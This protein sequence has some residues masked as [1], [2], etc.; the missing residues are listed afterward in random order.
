MKVAGEPAGGIE[1]GVPVA[2]EGLVAVPWAMGERW[3]MAY[4]SLRRPWRIAFS[5]GRG[6]RR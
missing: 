5:G 2:L 4:R 1:A 6:L 3:G